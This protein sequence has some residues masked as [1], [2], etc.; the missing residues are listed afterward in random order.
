MTIQSEPY[1]GLAIF[2]K[3]FLYNAAKEQIKILDEIE[4]NP[5]KPIDNF[6]FYEDSKRVYSFLNEKKIEFY[7]DKSLVGRIIRFVASVLSFF[8]LQRTNREV[9]NA[10][11]DY[12]FRLEAFAF[13]RENRAKNIQISLINE[14]ENKV[15]EFKKSCPEVYAEHQIRVTPLDAKQIAKIARYDGLAR[16]CLDKPHLLRKLFKATIRNLYPVSCFFQ[17]PKSSDMMHRNHMSQLVCAYHNTKLLKRDK[18]NHSLLLKFD[19]LNRFVDIM[20]EKEVKVAKDRVVSLQTIY[21]DFHA[22]GNYLGEYTMFRT[23]VAFWAIQESWKAYLN[24]N[25]PLN[26][27]EKL[28]EGI[29]DIV[30]FKELKTIFH[31]FDFEEGD[32]IVSFAATRQSVDRDI[33]NSH[34]FTRFYIPCGNGKYKVYSPGVF[35]KVWPKSV[36]EKLSFIGNTVDAGWCIPDPNH[37]GMPQRS[38][39]EMPIIIKKDDHPGQIAF[40]TRLKQTF[41]DPT[42][43]FAWSG[44][45]CAVPSIKLTTNCPRGDLVLTSISDVKT[46]PILWIW[47]KPYTYAPKVLKPAIIFCVLVSIGGYRKRHGKS[48]MSSNKGGNFNYPGILHEF[49]IMGVDRFGRKV[50]GVIS[51]GHNR[52]HEPQELAVI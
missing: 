48:L 42:L 37:A 4:L 49:I 40:H 33:N 19:Y 11:D 22:Q 38:K 52:D 30:T 46:P 20:R 7:G 41:L 44:D 36:W 6:N 26:W 39:A 18:I 21:D 47:V 29:T 51:G 27:Y 5:D 43:T 23:G 1:P 32:W 34:G 24:E 15:L 3:N 12:A 9:E 50:V 17:Y 25:S 45:N 31:A 13:R 14:L 16:L 10:L 28:P 35:S 2:R 8:K